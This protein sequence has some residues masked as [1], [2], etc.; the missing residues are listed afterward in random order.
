M[1]AHKLFG[2]RDLYEILEID[3]NAQIHDGKN[4]IHFVPSISLFCS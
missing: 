2:T 1:T 4:I 3:R